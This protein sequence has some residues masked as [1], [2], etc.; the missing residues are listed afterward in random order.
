M[1][2]T[3]VRQLSSELIFIWVTDLAGGYENPSP[4]SVSH[5]SQQ[6]G[7]PGSGALCILEITFIFVSMSHGGANDAKGEITGVCCYPC[8][9]KML[10]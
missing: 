6:K 8:P 3:V 2:E 4:C 9:S 5:P 1:E 7:R 10:S